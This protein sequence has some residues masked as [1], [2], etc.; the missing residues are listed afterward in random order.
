MRGRKPIGPEL[1]EAL[2]GSSL[3]RHRMRV[4]LETLAGHKRVRDACVA[5]EIC[6]QRFEAIRAAAIQAGIDALELKP[7]GRPAKV[8]S[9]ANAEIARL[10]GRIAELEA[11]LAAAQVRAELALT[12]PHLG[13]RL[14]K[15]ARPRPRRPRPTNRSRPGTST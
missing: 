4:V 2:E 10:N 3:A 11:A 13:D 7:A 9:A 8:V 6:P 15:K 1:A 12:L 14:A 5:L